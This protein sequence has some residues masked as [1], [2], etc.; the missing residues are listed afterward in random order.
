MSLA[1]QGDSVSPD[2]ED[3]AARYKEVQRQLHAGIVALAQIPV[4]VA[5]PTDE[6]SLQEANA[7]ALKRIRRQEL[8]DELRA[9]LE[10]LYPMLPT[11][12][13]STP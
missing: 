1:D 3:L 7:A 6:K 2:D 11:N 10:R 5:D 13:P 8:N 4:L 12:R 9:E